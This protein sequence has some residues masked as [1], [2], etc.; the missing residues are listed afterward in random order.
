MQFFIA[1]HHYYNFMW[2]NGKI[3]GL[4]VVVTA[5]IFSAGCTS[6][7]IG[8]A[9]PVIT[10]VATTGTGDETFLSIYDASLIV[11]ENGLKD[12][13]A[14]LYSSVSNAGITY[15]PSKLRLAALDLKNAADNYHTSLL[16]I[17]DFAIKENEYKRNEHLKYLST[18]GTVGGNIAEAAQAE[19]DNDYRLAMNYVEM[20]RTHLQRIEGVPN[21]AHRDLIGVMKVHLDDYVQRMRDEISS[22]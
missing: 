21:Q 5:L 14:N 9:T 7:D 6:S 3:L 4:L 10:P 11:I 12:V 1:G 17:E 18:I 15:S 20:G 2:Q 22:S 8:P 19:G 13:D 16:K